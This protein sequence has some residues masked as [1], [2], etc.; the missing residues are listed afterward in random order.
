M[1]KLFEFLKKL[2]TYPVY[3]TTLIIF[4]A[5]FILLPSAV[6]DILIL[7]LG[8]LVILF[9]LVRIT[10]TVSDNKRGTVSIKLIAD[11]LLG[12]AGVALTSMQSGVTHLICRVL[13]MIISLYAL[14]K[15]FRHSKGAHTRDRKFWLTA[16]LYIGLVVVGLWLGF[17]PIWPKVMAGIAALILA[18]KFIHDYIETKR[19][20]HGKMENGVYYTDDF[21]DKT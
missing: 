5:L 15:L 1:Q 9:A 21:E 20:A 14:A 12:I 7:V 16:A 8:V 10:I 17:F 18:G 11:I 6:L 13:G 3:V 4:G 19:D 2:N